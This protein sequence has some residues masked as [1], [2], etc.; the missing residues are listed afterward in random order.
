MKQ[1]ANI[2][3]RNKAMNRT[4]QLSSNRGVGSGVNTSILGT[5]SAFGSEMP[6]VIP[7]RER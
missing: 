5:A 7:T 3:F 2:L 4:A 6:D 1:S